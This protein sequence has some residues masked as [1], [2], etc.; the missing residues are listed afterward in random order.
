MGKATVSSPFNSLKWLTCDVS[1]K[2]PYFIQ[3]TDYENTQTYLAQEV[4]LIWHQNLLANLQRNV[5]QLEGRIN[6]QI[7]RLKGLKYHAKSI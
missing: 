5:K 3:Q 4:I 7:L 1:L 6:N 2:Y